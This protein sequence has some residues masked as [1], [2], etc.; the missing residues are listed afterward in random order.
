MSSWLGRRSKKPW[1]V[2]YI[3][4]DVGG[5]RYYFPPE[6]WECEVYI[7]GGIIFAFWRV[8]YATEIRYMSYTWISYFGPYE[9]V[10]YDQGL[11]P[12]DIKDKIPSNPPMPNKI[13]EGSEKT[14]LPPAPLPTSHVCLPPFYGRYKAL[15]YRSLVLKYLQ[16]GYEEDIAELK[17]LAKVSSDE[18]TALFH[19]IASFDD[20]SVPSISVEDIVDLSYSF[21]SANIPAFSDYTAGVYPWEG[22]LTEEITAPP[23][24]AYSPFLIDPVIYNT[25]V[26]VSDA[27]IV[28][29]SLTSP[30]LFLINAED[31]SI[32]DTVRVPEVLLTHAWDVSDS[33]IVVAGTQSHIANSTFEV[34]AGRKYLG[35][36]LTV[37][38]H[39]EGSFGN[40]VTYVFPVASV[41]GFDLIDNIPYAATSFCNGEVQYTNIIDTVSRSI[42]FREELH[43]PSFLGTDLDNTRVSPLTSVM[44]FKHGDCIVAAIVHS[45]TLCLGQTKNMV[46]FC[47]HDPSAESTST[48]VA[49]YYSCRI[50]TF[51]LPDGYY[52]ILPLCANYLSE[53]DTT[54]FLLAG[55]NVGDLNA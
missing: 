17:A 42:L 4:L 55:Y 39:S 34:D 3:I 43:L 48:D 20:T 35:T 16:E 13:E 32:I 41:V 7:I 40:G 18:S 5:S 25:Y 6:D 22:F 29:G 2:K 38:E 23:R 50:R 45:H 47:T 49:T 26:H 14:P 19:S 37:L 52:S 46:T 11:S 51:N 31:L 54:F 30:Y 10:R 21:H 28:M 27:Y 44:F 12:S 15:L 8:K 9:G 1:E 36:R 53:E 33:R 24:G